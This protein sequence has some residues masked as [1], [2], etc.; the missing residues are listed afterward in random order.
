M[1]Q[2]FIDSQTKIEVKKIRR[3][4]EKQLVEAKYST[5]KKFIADIS[6]NKKEVEQELEKSQK[7]LKLGEIDKD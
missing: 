4:K 7:I 1:E 6:L 5:L 3:R 2:S